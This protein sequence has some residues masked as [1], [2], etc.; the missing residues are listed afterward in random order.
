MK[1]KERDSL[2]DLRPYNVPQV[3][4]DIFLD[5][6]ENPYSM[7]QKVKEQVLANM[8]SLAFN[9][10][11]EITAHSLRVALA[12]GLGLSIENVQVGN[13]SSELIAACCQV[14]GGPGRKVAYPYPSFSMYEVY[15][16]LSDSQPCPYRLAEDFSLD[17]AALKDFLAKEQPDILIICNPNN[18]TGTLAQASAVREVLDEANCLVLLDEAYMEFADQSLLPALGDYPQLVVLRTFSKAY[19]L[20]SA[21]VGYMAAS[22]AI[23]S[24]LGKALLPYHVNALSLLVAETVYKERAAYR[25]LIDAIAS[26][27]DGLAAS[28][29]GLGVK[30]YPSAANFLFFSCGEQSSALGQFLLREGILARDFTAQPALGGIRL[31]VGTTEENEKVLAAVEKFLA[32]GK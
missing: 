20:A 29:A 22:A 7:P 18:P 21:R 26:A 31:T 23:S 27:R 25:P 5:A 28:L 4:A 14:F 17:P 8:A 6:N 15:A 19:G 10:Y 13:G 3:K 11:P 30:V 12:G 16:R 2:K 1:I 9:R 24:A 32:A